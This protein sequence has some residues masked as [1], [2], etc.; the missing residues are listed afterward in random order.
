[1]KI[2]SLQSVT[3]EIIEGSNKATIKGKI[4][5]SSTKYEFR[6]TVTS[7]RGF[8]NYAPD[9]L[10]FRV[11]PDGFHIEGDAV[12]KIHDAKGS[13]WAVRIE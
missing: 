9:D 11:L 2:A 10:T 7:S 1:M 6:G 5:K 12:D 8:K 13:F 4:T 3:V